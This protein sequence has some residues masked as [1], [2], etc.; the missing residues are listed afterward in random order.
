MAGSKRHGSS[1]AA[2]LALQREVR[3]TAGRRMRALMDEEAEEDEAFWAQDQF[4]DEEADDEYDSQESGE[5][6]EDRADSDFS[7]SEDEDDGEDDGEE[8]LRKEERRQ[9]R[10]KALRAPGWKK[11]QQQQQQQQEAR[12]K[13]KQK[14]KQKEVDAEATTTTTAA[15]EKEEKRERRTRGPHAPGAT[16]KDSVMAGPIRQSSRASV[17]ERRA[18]EVVAKRQR[19]QVRAPRVKHRR[20]EE[21]PRLTQSELLAEAARTEIANLASLEELQRIEEAVKAKARDEGTRRKYTG[22]IIRY[23]SSARPSGTLPSNAV[24]IMHTDGSCVDEDPA[25]VLGLRISDSSSTQLRNAPARS[26]QIVS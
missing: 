15:D 23:R 22:T 14:Q 8:K 12:A 21:E 9:G 7:D 26:A 10:A 6:S 3:V 24:I 1:S 25:Q 13:Q 11:K 2:P 5:E 19:E 16:T 18:A 17:L 4:A 20:R